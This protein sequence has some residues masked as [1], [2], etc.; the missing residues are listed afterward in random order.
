MSLQEKSNAEGKPIMFIDELFN[1]GVI[2]KR[3]FSLWIDE[4]EQITYND[5]KFIVR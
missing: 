3:L 4:L 1:Q 2:E 5:S